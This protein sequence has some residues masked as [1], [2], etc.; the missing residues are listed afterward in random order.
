MQKDKSGIISLTLAGILTLI[1]L[2][3]GIESILLNRYRTKHDNFKPIKDVS[4]EDNLKIY[5]DRDPE[6]QKC[7][8]R[9]FDLCQ[10]YQGA[11]IRMND[12]KPFA[13]HKNFEKNGVRT[14][15]ARQINVKNIKQYDKYL[16]Q[17]ER[18]TL[19]P[20][21]QKVYESMKHS[22]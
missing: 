19:T 15:F 13:I 17:Y 21:Y 4:R 1:L 12:R 22:K 16:T 20:L 2:D 6:F 9:Y 7:A 3:L 14:R 5:S 10:D 11:V 8:R 18:D